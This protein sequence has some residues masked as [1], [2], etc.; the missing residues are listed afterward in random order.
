M[1]VD[2]EFA[3]PARF[4]IRASGE[5]TLG[6]IEGAIRYGLAHPDLPG[7]DVLVDASEVLAVPST[8]ELR[9]VAREL[10]P[11]MDHGMVAVGFV[12]K[13]PFVYGVARMFGV[14]AEAVGVKFGAFREFDDA[15][16]WLEERRNEA[17]AP[18]T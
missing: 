10:V 8:P 1:P 6:E 15:S 11:L 13:S 16:S 5:V 4:K 14:F 18:R 9:Q 3:K 7:A 2:I 17:S 12:S